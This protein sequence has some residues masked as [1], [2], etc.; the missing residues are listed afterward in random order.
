MRSTLDW[1]SANAKEIKR[2]K[3]ESKIIIE[4]LNKI[5]KDFFRCPNVTSKTILIKLTLTICGDTQGYR[6]YSNQIE[7]QKSKKNK[8][9]LPDD[10]KKPYQIVKTIFDWKVSD[11]KKFAN[12]EWLYDLHWYLEEG[13]LKGKLLEKNNRNE[14]VHFHY[15]LNAIP[16]VMECE[17]NNEKNKKR[18]EPPIQYTQ[19]RYDFQKLLISNAELRLMVFQKKRLKNEEETK[20]RF[21]LLS[22]YFIKAINSCE[23]LPEKS[24]F[25]FVL[26]DEDESNNQLQFSYYEKGT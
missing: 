13:D 22:R 5:K 21:E 2:L 18:D 19:V 25:L 20:K 1:H 8:S 15:C 9:D 23:F 4:G 14:K 11:F 6:V 12:T 7:P 17:F 24:K 26:F 16:L 10:Y 3:C